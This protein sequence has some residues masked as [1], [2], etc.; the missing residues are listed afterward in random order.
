MM[1][2]RER[3]TTTTSVLRDAETEAKTGQASHAHVLSTS[4]GNLNVE[5]G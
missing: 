5:R 1:D 2:G 4:G 3:C